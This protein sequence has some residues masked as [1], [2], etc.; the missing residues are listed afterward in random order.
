MVVQGTSRSDLNGRSGFATAFDG[1][2]GRFVV[3]LDQFVAG[4]RDGFKVK[5]VNLREDTDGV[6][7]GKHVV[8]QNTTRKELN[9]SIGIATSFQNDTGRYTVQ[10][11][12]H[13]AKLLALKPENLEV[14]GIAV[15][16]S[17]A[18]NN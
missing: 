11:E 17:F 4:K 18:R 3:E 13:Q 9:G 1:E 16:L 14:R 6:L 2:A 8:V 15:N 5:P 10:V 12:G 7:C